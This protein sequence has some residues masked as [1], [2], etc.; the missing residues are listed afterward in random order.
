LPGIYSLVETATTSPGRWDQIIGITLFSGIGSH[1]NVPKEVFS[2][3]Y[4]YR[5]CPA[6][7]IDPY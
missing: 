6:E 3:L 7:K 4:G 1:A 5:N 2:V